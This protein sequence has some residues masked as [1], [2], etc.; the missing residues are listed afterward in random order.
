[1]TTQEKEE[2]RL[3]KEN[4]ILD[5]VNEDNYLRQISFKHAQVN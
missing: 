5:A 3:E 2:K 1:M 4:M